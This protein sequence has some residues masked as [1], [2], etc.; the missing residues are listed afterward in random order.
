M[1]NA[2]RKRRR[3]KDKAKALTNEDL[4]AVMTIREEKRREA[5]QEAKDHAGASGSKAEPVAPTAAAEKDA[6][7]ASETR[8]KAAQTP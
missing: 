2:E 8:S 5:E 7:S 6:A 4:F 3:L 1:R